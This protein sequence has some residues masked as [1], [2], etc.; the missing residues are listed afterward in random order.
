MLLYASMMLTL[1]V[2]SQ[3]RCTQI[4][5]NP[6]VK[7]FN[8]CAVS[9][10]GC[11]ATKKSKPGELSETGEQQGFGPP[12]KEALDKSFNIQ[13]WKVGHQL[14]VESPCSLYSSTSL[15]LLCHLIADHL[16]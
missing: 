9:E 16:S 12:P 6:A 4:H 3:L 14:V 11:V 2:S 7:E 10:H 13:D 1:A 15:V 8:T 5:E